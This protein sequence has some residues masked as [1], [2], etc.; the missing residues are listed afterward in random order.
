MPSSMNRASATRSLD[1]LGASAPL[2]A[3]VITLICAGS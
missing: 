2:V 3:T 1:A